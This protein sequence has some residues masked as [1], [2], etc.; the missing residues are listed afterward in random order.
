MASI[1]WW[2]FYLALACICDNRL[3]IYIYNCI[4]KYICIYD[5]AFLLHVCA[6]CKCFFF[7][8]EYY[9]RYARKCCMPKHSECGRACACVSRGLVLPAHFWCVILKSTSVIT[10]LRF[11]N[12]IDH[13]KEIILLFPKYEYARRQHMTS[14]VNSHKTL[15]SMLHDIYIIYIYIYYNIWYSVGWAPPNPWYPPCGVGGGGGAGGGSSSSNNNCSAN[16]SSNNKSRS[17]CRS[18]SRSSNN[19]TS[20]ASTTE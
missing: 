6:C 16:S 8:G 5:M 14:Y 20:T 9:G 4:H 3:Y 7:A 19:S 15:Q 13:R 1:L 12:T 2:K 17:S 18:S 11:A 10:V